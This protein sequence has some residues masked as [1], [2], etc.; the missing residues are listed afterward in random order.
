MNPLAH[1]FTKPP[2]LPPD[3]TSRL[4]PWLNRAHSVFAELLVAVGMRVESRWLDCNTGWPLPTMEEWAGKPLAFRVFLDE[5]PTVIAM[6]NQLAQVLA[7]SLLGEAIG[8]DIAE[9]SLSPVEISLCEMVV[10][11][12]LT[13]LGEAWID[14][15]KVELEQRGI[16][17]NLRRS[18]IFRPTDQLL[19]CRSAIRVGDSEH[20]WT[21]MM[22]L[23]TLLELFISEAKAVALP[24]T[25]VNRREMESLVRE[26]T[27]P[28][29]VNLGQVRL[30][31][32]QLAEL[33]VGD[34]VMLDQRTGEPMKAFISGE[35]AFVGWPGQ[36]GNKQ[37]FQVEA[38]LKKRRA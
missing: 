7:G 18:R 15:S 4:V 26:M 38:E 6:P 21:W 8:S 12:F 3:V 13:S 32:P 34:V 33:Q 28:L 31:T 24:P 37:A 25:E 9:R 11:T 35:P 10:K 1:D 36:V 5:K 2:R 16:E 23:E 17:M 29:V 27:L 30:S 14:E 20:L 19:L 22:Q